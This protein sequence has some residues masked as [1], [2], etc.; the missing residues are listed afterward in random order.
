MSV[1]TSRAIAHSPSEQPPPR[2]ASR[3]AV[4]A[5]V[6]QQLVTI[7]AIF[8]VGVMVGHMIGPPSPEHCNGARDAIACLIQSVD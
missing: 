3:R 8:L 4:P 2:Y 1:S 7:P 5:A 6:L